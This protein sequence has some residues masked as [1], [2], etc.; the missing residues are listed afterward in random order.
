MAVCII[1][2]C[3]LTRVLILQSSQGINRLR[4]GIIME[5]V[6]FIVLKVWMSAMAVVLLRPTMMVVIN[7]ATKVL[8]LLM[9]LPGALRD[10]LNRIIATNSTLEPDTNRVTLEPD[11][12]LIWGLVWANILQ[13]CETTLKIVVT[14]L[15]LLQV[16]V[17]HTGATTCTD[18]LPIFNHHLNS[19]RLTIL[20]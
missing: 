19:L 9:H 16:L 8:S 14:V 6:V 13:S 20:T 10:P 15:L 12:L 17:D 11:I 1:L 7:M 3:I 5:A 2:I 18:R 4:A